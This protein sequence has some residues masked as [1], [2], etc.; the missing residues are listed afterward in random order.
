M[1][2]RVPVV[3]APLPPGVPSSAPP[4]HEDSPVLREMVDNL[5]EQDA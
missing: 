4:P 3:T 5:V 2:R 1:K